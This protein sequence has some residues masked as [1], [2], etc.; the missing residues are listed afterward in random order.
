MVTFVFTLT[1]PLGYSGYVQTH[2]ACVKEGLILPVCF[3]SAALFFRKLLIQGGGGASLSADPTVA[4][5]AIISRDSPSYSTCS[6]WDGGISLLLQ[7]LQLGKRN[8]VTAL[9]PVP[10]CTLG[11]G[12]VVVKAWGVGIKKLPPLIVTSSLDADTL[13][14]V[15]H[16]FARQQVG[17][18]TLPR[19]WLDD[20]HPLQSA[21]RQKKTLWLWKHKFCF[22]I[23][24][25]IT[26]WIR[27]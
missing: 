13:W 5:W 3:L 14:R 19:S 18:H 23:S 2:S 6:T 8:D 24:L 20:F 12:V 9:R 1:M 10:H 11:G 15:P 16:T 4:S 26:I 27:K 7:S 25:E 17:V 21:G 22:C